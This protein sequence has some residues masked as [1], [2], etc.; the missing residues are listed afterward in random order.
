MIGYL[1][2]GGGLGVLLGALFTVIAMAN[3]HAIDGETIHRYRRLNENLQDEVVSLN[4]EARYLRECNQ[5]LVPY[6]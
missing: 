3:K 1:L 5:Q 2:I 6:N 4:K